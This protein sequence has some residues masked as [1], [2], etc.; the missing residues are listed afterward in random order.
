MLALLHLSVAFAALTVDPPP[1]IRIK[2]SDDVVAPG[3]RLKTKVRVEADGYLVVLRADSR[4]RVRV[5]FPIDPTDSNR[6]RGGRDFEIRG[7]GDR[8]GFMVD[9][10]EG[11]G[12]VLAAVSQTPFNFRAL[13]AGDSAADSTADPEAQAVGVIDR[14]A[15]GDYDYDIAAYGVSERAYDR[16]AGWGWHGRWGSWGWGGWGRGWGWG[17]GG[18]WYGRPGIWIGT[19]IRM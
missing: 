16:R 19:R 18:G 1:P 12:V 13:A 5:L 4:G 15:D 8:D 6:I 9:D 10:R 14:M 3:E 2:L 11:S 17:W 7:R